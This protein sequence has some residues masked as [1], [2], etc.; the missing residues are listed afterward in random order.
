MKDFSGQTIGEYQ[1][2]K[3]I[4]NG[5][6]STVY[7]AVQGNRQTAVKIFPV[8][9]EEAFRRSM[10]HI[11]QHPRIVPIV[12]YGIINGMGYI[13]MPLIP[14]ESLEQ[15]LQRGQ[16][17]PDEAA[18]ILREVAAVLDAL[19]QQ[20]FVYRT[21]VP[22]DILLDN[23]GQVWL[24]EFHTGWIRRQQSTTALTRSGILE[25]SPAYMSPEMWVGDTGSQASDVY[26]LGVIAFVMLTGKLPFPGAT[27]YEMM[28]K[29]LRAPVPEMREISGD[30]AD[31]VKKALA[32]RPEDRFANAGEFQR[33]I[34]Q[35]A[36][37]EPPPPPS[38]PSPAPVV[39]PPAPITSVPERQPAR[40]IF[41]PQ[42]Q[43]DSEL[44]DLFVDDARLQ[45][46]RDRIE[47]LSGDSAASAYQSE[48]RL[49]ADLLAESRENYDEARAIVY[50]VQ[51]D[52]HRPQRQRARDTWTAPPEFTAFY[53][54][55][56]QAGQAYALMVFVALPSVR[57]RI[58]QVASQYQGMMG[59]SQASAMTPSAIQVAEGTPITLV[60]QI[61]GI[62]LNPP[63]QILTWTPQTN[64][65]KSATFLFTTPAA[66]RTDLRGRVL[67]FHG[68][69]ILGE[70]PVLMQ[71]VES[72]A[73]AELSHK[74]ELHEFESVFASYS[75]RDTPVMEFFRRQRERLGQKMLVDVYDLRAGD[76]WAD[77]LLEMIDESSVFQLF[78]SRHSAASQY[79]R[80]EWEHALRYLE[81]RPRFIQPVW[82]A[83]P[84]P[85]PPPELE[86][87]HF[88]RIML[89]PLT[90]M[91]LIASQ[92]RRLW[93][94]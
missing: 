6:K 56:V 82:W 8:N 61:E 1:I 11:A 20:G 65:Y 91:Q 39:A 75:H 80:Q 66:L 51:A 24:T 5:E 28:A 54:E 7:A 70:L 30:L 86:R 83:E 63:E 52:M 18:W 84:M 38:P 50:R 53:P 29:H 62:Q 57:N 67:V 2:G 81:E 93:K 4:Y 31:A 94:R 48:L 34:A 3:Q 43:A 41:A 22:S 73:P 9:D 42:A 77:R 37:V 90:R 12:T 85:S 60:P 59:G 88:Q 74:A 25:G 44:L 36:S 55:K 32:K 47:A 76:H 45:E 78:W 64:P 68:P 40:E 49:A 72:G 71:W 10:G 27:A 15:R 92:F 16:L 58:Q 19:H 69:L 21:L 14:G 46:L 87:L 79:C 26:A 33:A 13:V 17:P 35:T 23:Q 89:P